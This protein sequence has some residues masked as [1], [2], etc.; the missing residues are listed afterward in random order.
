MASPLPYLFFGG[1]LFSL[2]KQ[3]SAKE[4]GKKMKEGKAKVCEQK[5]EGRGADGA[6]VEICKGAE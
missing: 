5:E 3:S 6:E 2:H 1:S 4:R